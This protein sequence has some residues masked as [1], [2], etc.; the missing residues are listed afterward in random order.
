M[1]WFAANDMRMIRLSGIASG[2]HPRPTRAVVGT[3]AWLALALLLTVALPAVVSGESS[4]EARM[5]ARVNAVRATNGLPRLRIDPRL[6]RAA[7]MQAE[8]MAKHGFL[9]HQGSNGSTLG[10]RARATG[11]RFRSVAENLAAGSVAPERVVADWERSAGHRRNLLSPGFDDAGIGHA[12]RPQGGSGG[13]HD[14]WSL[15]LGRA[16]DSGSSPA[17]DLSGR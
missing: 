13:F 6:T 11:Y 16:L 14:Y 4:L 1:S 2:P 10:E 3:G 12:R 15:V 8:D 9:S 5:L 17:S 7:R